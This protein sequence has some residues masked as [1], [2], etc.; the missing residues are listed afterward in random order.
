MN[1][2]VF[3]RLAYKVFMKAYKNDKDG[4]TIEENLF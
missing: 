3:L 1:L 4:C 2:G